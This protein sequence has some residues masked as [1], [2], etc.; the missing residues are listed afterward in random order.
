M[1]TG[2]KKINLA[3]I[4]EN[5]GSWEGEKNYIHSLISVLSQF[6][7]KNIDIKIITSKNNATKLKKLN[8]QD[9]EILSS[10][11]L[12]EKNILNI[13]KKISGKIFNTF[14][15]VILYLIKK[16]KIDIISHYRP[17]HFA[18]TICWMPDFQHYHYPENFIN[19]EIKRRNNLYE[20]IMHNSNLV[21]LSSNDAI[22]DLKKFKINKKIYYKKLNFVPFID[23][24]LLKKINIHKKYNIK[25]KYFIV[26]N[27]FWK[28]KNHICLVNALNLI[29]NKNIDFQIV[30]TGDKKSQFDNKTFIDFTKKIRE[31]K[32]QKYFNYLGKIPY[33]DLINLI[34][35]SHAVINPS[36]FE[37]WSTIVEEAK[38][39]NKSIIL[40]NINVHK[41]Q[42][43]KNSF[44]FSPK[45]PGK[46]S[47]I[48]LKL[49]A[50]KIKFINKNKLNTN[51]TLKRK[52]FAN[53]F[54][55]IVNYV[56]Y[57]LI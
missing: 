34:Y 2:L 44:Y 32:L 27:Q 16:Y 57:K 3:F 6:K 33:D 36:F 49:S 23:F 22:N 7:R 46:L 8:L 53:N 9:I 43:P 12:S 18:K 30:L 45:E 11:F 25:K 37:G 50:K 20:N 4:L 10:N 15:P 19:K 40:S 38:I 24:N 52:Q 31:N 42:K 39:L 5:L 48:L 35:N 1:P 21:L 55:K 54:V 56:N 41:E 26:P 17:T 13:F 14:D 28:H 47:K 51:F 29:E